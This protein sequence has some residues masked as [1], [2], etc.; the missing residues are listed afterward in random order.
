M[1]NDAWPT[2]PYAEWASTKK[3]LHLCAQMLGK[4][5][6]A[7][8]P[9]QPEWLHSCLYIDP[10]GFTTGAMPNGAQV[11]S[12]GIDLFDRVLWLRAGDGRSTSLPL[13][14]GRSIAEIWADFQAA[15]RLWASR[16]TCGRSLRRWRTSPSSRRTP[17]RAFSIP[18]LRSVSTACSRASR[19]SSRSSARPSSAA[20]ACSSGGATFDLAVLLFTGRQVTPPEDLGYIMRYDLDAQHMNAG[21]W[22]GDDAT[23]GGLLRL[24]RPPSAR[25]RPR[26]HRTRT[27]QL[28]GGDGGVDPPLRQSANKQGCPARGAHLS[29]ECL[30]LRGVGRRVG[31]GSPSLCPARSSAAFVMPSPGRERSHHGRV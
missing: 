7:L 29:R 23:P 25:L 13:V 28:G 31:G 3:T 18:S 14:S 1:T 8:A 21:F 17:R 19:A 4:V 6:L 12:A 22:P 20:A 16:S 5:R 24:P 9:P 15:L 11:V 10:R 26:R 27:L 2:L 30:S